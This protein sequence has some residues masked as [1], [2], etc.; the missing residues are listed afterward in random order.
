M[1]RSDGIEVVRLEDADVL[2]HGGAV[3]DMASFGMVLM[4]VGAFDQQ[5][6]SVD[7]NQAFFDSNVTKSNLELGGL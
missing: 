6:F 2:F 7:F 1:R 3:D 4:A 5:V